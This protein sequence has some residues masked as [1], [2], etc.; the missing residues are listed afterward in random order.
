MKP[1]TTATKE[2]ETSIAPKDGDVYRFAYNQEQ[3]E[4]AR[5]DL[6]WCFDGQL[7]YRDGL[8]CDTYW[9]LNWRGD[10]G[11]SFTVAKAQSQGILEFVCNLNDVEK[12]REDE[13]QLYADG[14][15]FNLS[16]QH[17]CYK[18]YVK[19]R[20]ARKDKERMLAAVHQKVT[21]ARND[22]ERAVRN[23]EHAVR[24]CEQL[25]PRIEAGEEPSI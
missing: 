2:P 5:G 20:G 10:N 21:D 3:Y 8:L 6:R 18:H 13:Y 11:R 24:R 25:V 16:H 7:V 17:G 14:D 15:T 23:L 9:G 4:R 1:E 22:V 12:I 19:R